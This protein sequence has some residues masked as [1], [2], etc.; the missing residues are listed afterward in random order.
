MALRG[1][2]FS[3][4]A[5]REF[6]SGRNYFSGVLFIVSFVLKG[7]FKSS[8]PNVAMFFLANESTLFSLSLSSSATFLYFSWISASLDRSDITGSLILEGGACS[9]IV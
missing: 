1:K 2:G 7:S 9:Y 6:G 3:V 5:L 8:E 4:L